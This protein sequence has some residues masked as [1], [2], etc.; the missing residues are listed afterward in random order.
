MQQA[1]VHICMM[2]GYLPPAETASWQKCCSPSDRTTQLVL[3]IPRVLTPDTPDA[4][5]IALCSYV[6]CNDSRWCEVLKRDVQTP[7]TTVFV[8]CCATCAAVSGDK[9]T[10]SLHVYHTAAVLF[11]G[12]FRPEGKYRNID[13]VISIFWFDSNSWLDTEFS[14]SSIQPI[15]VEID[16]FVGDLD[17][18]LQH[19]SLYR[20]FR[21]RDGSYLW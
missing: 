6:H 8:V 1:A 13:I 20:M 14:W 10:T 21:N 16:I 15:E 18:D 7:R 2:I 4:S 3:F 11:D 12:V 19:C 9:E 5:F 17:P